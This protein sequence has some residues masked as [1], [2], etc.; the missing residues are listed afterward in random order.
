MPWGDNTTRVELAAS[1]STV[2]IVSI[3][4]H[5]HAPKYGLLDQLFIPLLSSAQQ[6][7]DLM[8]LRMGDDKTALRAASFL[9]GE[10]LRDNS[11]APVRS[12]MAS[13]SHVYRIDLLGN[14]FQA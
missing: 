13:A 3:P 1:G 10:L 12:L 6:A 7:N 5:F 2:D 8:G 14:N 9:A 4:C 11:F